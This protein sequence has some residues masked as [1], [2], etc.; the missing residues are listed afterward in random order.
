VPGPTTPAAAQANADGSYHVQ[1]NATDIG[2]GARTA[3]WQIAADAL[4]VPPERVAI[5]I[6]DSTLSEAPLAGGS[7]GMASWGWAVTKACRAL[8]ERIH[9]QYGGAVPA[10]GVRVHVNTAEEVNAMPTYS[11]HAFGAHFAEVR[12]DIDT[13]E[14]RVTRLLGVFAAGHI[15]NAT[16]ARSQLIGGMTMGLSM[17]LHEEGQLDPRFGDWVN[18]DLA[19]Y[20][21]TAHADVE[22][23]EAVWIDEDDP[24]VNPVGIKGVGEIGIVGTAAAIANAVHHATGV[25]VRDLPVRLDKLLAG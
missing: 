2:T 6:G 20:H 11:R 18:H 12:V 16:T 5:S 24:R 8:R 22:Q 17:A 10:N 23:I 13:G 1:I 14:T 21:I 4:G 3:L 25:R 9:D 7:M 19:S 15:V